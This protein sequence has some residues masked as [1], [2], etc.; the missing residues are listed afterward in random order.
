MLE[1][2]CY[3]PRPK[4][5]VVAN[6][7]IADVIEMRDFDVIEKDGILYF[8]GISD[9]AILANHHILAKI[10]VRSKNGVFTDYGRPFYDDVWRDLYG[11]MNEDEGMDFT[12][13]LCLLALR[14]KE[15][16]GMDA[17]KNFKGMASS[18]EK[19]LTNAMFKRKA[20]EL[21]GFLNS[22]RKG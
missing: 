22:F 1:I 21:H 8:G 17:R 5:S 18:F 3:G 11:S 16:K 10:S 6:K 20:W 4:V 2:A 7:A 19:R 15:D 12:I 13:P 9:D 14:E